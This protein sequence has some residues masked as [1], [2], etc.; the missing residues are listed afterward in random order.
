MLQERATRMATWDAEAIGTWNFV[1]WDAKAALG[2]A[3]PRRRG[4]PGRGRALAWD[5][6]NG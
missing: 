6:E 5:T 3:Y 2:K 4:L 1:A